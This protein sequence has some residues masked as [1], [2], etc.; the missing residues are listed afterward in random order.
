MSLETP[1]LKKLHATGIPSGPKWDLVIGTA[2]WYFFPITMFISHI[3]VT[4]KAKA[5]P[6]FERKNS[7][8]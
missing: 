2:A 7:W 4:K 5:Q 6:A 8:L 1:A 3:L